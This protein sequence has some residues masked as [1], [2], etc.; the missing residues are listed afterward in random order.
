MCPTI[1]CGPLVT[2]GHGPQP[3]FKKSGDHD[4][5]L[6]PVSILERRELQCFG[7]A[8]EKAA[9]TTALIP[10][11]PVAVAVFANQEK[12]GVSAFQR[13]RFTFV[14]DTRPFEWIA[15]DSSSVSQ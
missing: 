10:D 14:H 3:Q 8:N 2:A 12:R 13:G 9:A 4:Y 6:W 11:D 7:A 15:E 5:S 1:R